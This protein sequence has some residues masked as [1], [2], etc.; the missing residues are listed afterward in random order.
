MAG[1]DEKISALRAD[2][3]ANSQKFKKAEA[4]LTQRADS[5][6]TKVAEAEEQLDEALW[7]EMLETVEKELKPLYLRERQKEAEIVTRA[8]RL[9]ATARKAAD[10]I[11]SIKEGVADVRGEIRSLEDRL[12]QADSD[13]GAKLKDALAAKKAEAASECEVP[14]HSDGA[15][16]LLRHLNVMAGEGDAVSQLFARSFGHVPEAVKRIYQAVT[17]SGGRLKTREDQLLMLSGVKEPRIIAARDKLARHLEDMQNQGLI[18]YEKE[19]DYY[20]VTAAAAPQA[21]MAAAQPSA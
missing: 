9:V 1:I 14:D 2:F 5:W 3:E 7:E 21:A 4:R 19:G 16:A 6:K 11:K 17:G 8:N 18:R 15:Y 12:I 10:K 13:G 20:S